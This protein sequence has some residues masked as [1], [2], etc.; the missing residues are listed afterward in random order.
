MP[1]FKNELQLIISI[2]EVVKKKGFNIKF[3][4]DYA[5]FRIIKIIYLLYIFIIF[6]QLK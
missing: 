3:P 1:K 2:R 4:S 6:F 5:T